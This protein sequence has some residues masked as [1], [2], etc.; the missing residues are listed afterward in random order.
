M[1]RIKCTCQYTSSCP[2]DVTEHL[3]TL[4]TPWGS[5]CWALQN[6]Q[7]VTQIKRTWQTA[8]SWCRWFHTC[9]KIQKNS[10]Q[11]Q[12]CHPVFNSS[13]ESSPSRF[14]QPLGVGYKHESEIQWRNVENSLRCSINSTLLV[15]AIY[16]PFRSSGEEWPLPTEQGFTSPRSAANFNSEEQRRVCSERRSQRSCLV[17]GAALLQPW[18]SYEGNWKFDVLK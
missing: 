16:M 7:R 15:W 4:K 13:L 5:W 17:H 9:P 14:S 11:M 18:V 6:G 12:N 10:C 8:N 3:L 1:Q 2:S